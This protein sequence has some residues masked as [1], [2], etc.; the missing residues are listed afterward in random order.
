MEILLGREPEGSKLIVVVDGKTYKMDTGQSVP[1]TVSRWDHKTSRAHCR[2]VIGTKGMRIENLND[3]NVTYVNGE[4]VESCA[5]TRTSVIELGDDQYRIDFARILKLIGYQPTYSLKHLRRVWEQYD[6]ELLN[7]QLEEKKKQ[8]QQKLQGII[9][10]VSMVCVIIPSVMPQFPL[11]PELRAVLVVG[12]LVMGIYFYIKG[13]KVDD[14]FIIKKR[15]LDER[16]KNEYV[17]PNPKCKAPLGTIPY[18]TLK[19]RKKCTVCNC[20]YHP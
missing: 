4:E 19:L 1:N 13:N 11:P 17:C 8:N 9:S 18:D 14:S 12:A 6:R 16:F 7:L 5:I 20:N 2:I 10:Q 3:E 15:E